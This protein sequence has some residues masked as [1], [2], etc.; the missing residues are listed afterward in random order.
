MERRSC[1]SAASLAV[2]R[3]PDEA[4]ETRQRHLE[5]HRTVLMTASGL[6]CAHPLLDRTLWVAVLADAFNATLSLND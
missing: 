4:L 1:E 6:Q 5:G 2:C 3:V